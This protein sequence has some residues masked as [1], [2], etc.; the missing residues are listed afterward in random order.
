MKSTKVAKRKAKV[1]K[2]TVPKDVR[3]VITESFSGHEKLYDAVGRLWLKTNDR[4]FEL[5]KPERFCNRRMMVAMNT[6]MH[7]TFLE[8]V[9]NAKTRYLHSKGVRAAFATKPK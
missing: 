1:R 5:P 4:I 9:D 6:M 2:P 8:N 3:A 7:D